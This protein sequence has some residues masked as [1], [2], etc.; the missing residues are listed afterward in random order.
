V[1]AVVVALTP[2]TGGPRFVR[3]P[4]LRT[5]K[6]LIPCNPMTYTNLLNS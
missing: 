1:L 6:S 4:L 3:C 2:H 5:W